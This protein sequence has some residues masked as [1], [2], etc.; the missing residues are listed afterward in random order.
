MQFK[1]LKNIIIIILKTP[2]IL[3]MLLM[4]LNDGQLKLAPV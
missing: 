4:L 3:I 1:A 2:N